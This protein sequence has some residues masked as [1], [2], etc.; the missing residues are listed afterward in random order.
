MGM[1][2]TTEGTELRHLVR[3]KQGTVGAFKVR[4]EDRDKLLRLAHSYA[5]RSKSKV[6]T[7]SAPIILNR[8][9]VWYIVF[10]TVL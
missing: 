4:I 5:V 2:K 3:A 1:F 10:V 6:E 8:T 9:D 7:E